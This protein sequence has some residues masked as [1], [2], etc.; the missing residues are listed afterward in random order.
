VALLIVQALGVQDG[1]AK[2]GRL[3]G[4]ICNSG[5]APPS[6]P[7]MRFTHVSVSGGHYRSWNSLNLTCVAVDCCAA[8]AA[9]TK[10][11]PEAQ[12]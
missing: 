6:D 9:D 7:T 3:N 4:F 2:G 1:R 12:W 10:H 11:A 5:A 8:S